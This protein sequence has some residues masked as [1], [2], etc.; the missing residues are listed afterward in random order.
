M[1]ILLLTIVN[2]DVDVVHFI[3][4][5]YKIGPCA[6]MQDDDTVHYLGCECVTNYNEKQHVRFCSLFG[7]SNGDLPE[8]VLCPAAL[9]TK[10]QHSLVPRP[11]PPPLF[12]RIQYHTVSDQILEVIIL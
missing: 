4:V 2:F 3:L 12:D 8:Y 11:F 5:C 6:V 10:T 1:W 7:Q 9:P